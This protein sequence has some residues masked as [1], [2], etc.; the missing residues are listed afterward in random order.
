LSQNFQNEL[1]ELRAMYESWV[2]ES[3]QNA[4]KSIRNMKKRILNYK[5]SLSNRIE[6]FVQNNKE[7]IRERLDAVIS[8]LVGDLSV[9]LSDEQI[10]RLDDTDNLY[11][12]IDVVKD[13]VPEKYHGMLDD[14][15]EGVHNSQ[16]KNAP[17][18]KDPQ[19]PITPNMWHHVNNAEL[20]RQVQTNY[21]Y[22]PQTGRKLSSDINIPQLA[23][24]FYKKPCSGSC[25]EY[26]C[27]KLVQTPELLI[28]M[29]SEVVEDKSISAAR[30]LAEV[31]KAPSYAYSSEGLDPDNDAAESGM[32]TDATVNGLNNNSPEVDPEQD[33]SENIGDLLSGMRENYHEDKEEEEEEDDDDDETN[34]EEGKEEDDNKEEEEETNEE[35]TGKS[36]KPVD[37][38]NTDADTVSASSV[39]VSVLVAAASLI[40]LL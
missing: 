34:H 30:L 35:E 25:E 27:Q 13:N 23:L 12:T 28:S 3:Q 31:R 10:D 2:R 24:P 26:L 8:D 38:A 9:E 5:K 1:T 15:K 4:K 16:D 20:I 22:S 11:D 32:N 19:E 37:K 40:L 21:R 36:H 6:N 29:T 18:V 14:I 17:I 7:R 33:K 39:V